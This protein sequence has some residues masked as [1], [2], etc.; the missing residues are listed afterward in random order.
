MKKSSKGT[1]WILPA[2]LILFILSVL[3]LP[4]MVVLTY[5]GRSETPKHI[6]TFANEQLTWD[7][8]THIQ[9]NGVA[10]LSFFSTVYQNVN[11]ENEDNVV[12]PGTDALTTIRLKNDSEITAEYTAVC[13]MIKPSDELPVHAGMEAEGSTPTDQFQLPE[14]VENAQVL[15]AVKG[16]VG[17][18]EIRDFDIN[19]YWTF[20]ESDEQDIRDTALGNKAAWEDP[21]DVLLG[22]YIVVEGETP[23]PPP[24]T[25]T[26]SW[27]WLGIVFVVISGA[28]F[29]VEL[30]LNRKRKKKENAEG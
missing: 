5:A 25:G 10:E 2:T 20:Y 3:T 14:G 15:N 24:H 4:L 7:D 9:D 19:W 22:F 11:S 29:T 1:G 21:D 17:S 6:L 12:A 30:I 13:Y 8:A 23:V 26:S 27:L 28:L 18:R 16:T